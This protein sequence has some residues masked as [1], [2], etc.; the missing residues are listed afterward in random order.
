M[1]FE[2][3]RTETGYEGWG[4]YLIVAIRQPDG[5]VIRRE[6]EDH[7]IAA[8][9]LPYDAARRTAILVR[10]FR[11]PVFVG[12]R[13]D[14]MLEAIAGTIEEEDA[15]TCARRE[16]M[17]EAGLR[18]GPLEHVVTGWAMPGIS[19]ERAALYLAPY[20]ES[21]RV[22][23]G[24]GVDEHETITVI[25]MT[26]AELARMADEGTLV[27]FKTLILVQALRLRRPELFG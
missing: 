9:V 21:D 25:E 20:R 22:A 12:E 16:A 5:T 8:A 15:E 23:A 1:A 10:Q 18:L 7:G 2:L 11:A 17:E 4:R 27:D 6:V 19:T 13:L 3:V 14:D 24:G 26:L